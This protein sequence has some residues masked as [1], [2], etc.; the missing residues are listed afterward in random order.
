MTSTLVGE[1]HRPS[2]NSSSALGRRTRRVCWLLVTASLVAALPTV[3]VDRVLNGPAVMN[4]SARGTAL[5][6]LVVA[7]PVLVVSLTRPAPSTR[8]HAWT[9]GAL[10][11][12]AYNAGLFVFATPFNELFLA[13]VAMLGLAVWAIVSALVDLPTPPAVPERLPA[14]PIAGFLVAVAAL[15]GLAWLMFV[16]PELDNVGD[17]AFLR[18]TGLTTNPIYVQDLAFAI[19]A[20]V[21]IA[22]LLWRRRPWGGL[23]AGAALVFWVVES[24]GVA[25]DQVLGHRADPSSE[26]ATYGGAAMFAVLGVLS[27]VALGGWLHHHASRR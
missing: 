26:V 20:V 24:F 11:Y 13:Y 17:P 1:M 25:V 2:P 8:T 15:N 27:C 23:L 12:L 9:L 5:I 14:R 22:V 10:A 16:V 7:V 3:L 6:V 21:A 18:G 19:P 4:G